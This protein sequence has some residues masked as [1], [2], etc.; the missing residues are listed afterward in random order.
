MCVKGREEE[1]GD[2]KKGEGRGEGE[3]KGGED[4][5]EGDT[6]GRGAVILCAFGCRTMAP[7][8]CRAM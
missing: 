7:S 6:K 3:R 8:R 4:G 1:K 5:R 2:R